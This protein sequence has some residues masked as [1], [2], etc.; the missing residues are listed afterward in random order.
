MTTIADYAGRTVDL[1]AFDDVKPYGETPLVMTLASQGN[2]GK[3]CAGPQKL[4]QKFL[5]RLFQKRGSCPFDMQDGS[6]FMTEAEGGYLQTEGD[7]E[8]AFAAAVSDIAILFQKE[9]TDT[10][11]ADECFESAEL[12]S[13]TLQHGRLIIVIR[14]ISKAGSDQRILLPIPVTV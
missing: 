2:S 10:D 6:Y 5:I 3:I 13:T 7:V 9:E 11:P 1:F 12:L 8:T 4:A 14:L